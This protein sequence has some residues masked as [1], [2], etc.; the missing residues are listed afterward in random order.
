[1]APFLFVYF[2]IYLRQWSIRVAFILIIKT[3]KN[4]V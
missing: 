4:E 2:G 3:Q 1:M